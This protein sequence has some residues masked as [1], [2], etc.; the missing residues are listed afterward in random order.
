MD[1]G[2]DGE[3]GQ[4]VEEMQERQGG[5][6]WLDL[7]L[8]WGCACGWEKGGEK[9]VGHLRERQEGEG[10]VAL[11]C[12]GWEEDVEKEHGVERDLLVC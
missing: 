11:G 3:V 2:K 7:G 10:W 1:Y 6:E 9:V 5:E 8:G 4:A 12:W